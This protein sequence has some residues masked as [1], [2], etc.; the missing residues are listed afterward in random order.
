M[1]TVYYF[2]R[3]RILTVGGNEAG[4]LESAELGLKCEPG[5]QGLRELRRGSLKRLIDTARLAGNTADLNTAMERLKKLDLA[6]DVEG[7]DLESAP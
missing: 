5:N 2:Q 7:A 1:S 3:G 4:A 6:A